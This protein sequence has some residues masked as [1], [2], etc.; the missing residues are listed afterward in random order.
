ME[1]ILT[2]CNK[3]SNNST[4]DELEFFKDLFNKKLFDN[5][6]GCREY[7]LINCHPDF[8]SNCFY[9]GSNNIWLDG[10]YL[11]FCRVCQRRFRVTYGTI[12]QESRTSLVNWFYVINLVINGH[13]IRSLTLSYDL[14]VCYRTARNLVKKSESII[15]FNEKKIRF[16]L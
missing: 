6:S 2:D 15:D 10:R 5:I 9:C 8:G 7:I 13:Q 12:F 1:V 16:L 3:F 11:Y 4:G 14:N